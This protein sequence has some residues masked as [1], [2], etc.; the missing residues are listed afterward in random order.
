MTTSN[1]NCSKKQGGTPLFAA[2][3]TN[4]INELKG[5][6]LIP[7]ESILNLHFTVLHEKEHKSLLAFDTATNHMSHKHQKYTHL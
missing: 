1:G 7:Q 2:L 5:I 6:E 4:S 3:A